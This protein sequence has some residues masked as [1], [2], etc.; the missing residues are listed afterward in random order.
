MR[1]MVDSAVS[2]FF[3]AKPRLK[4]HPQSKNVRYGKM[5]LRVECV[6]ESQRA[7]IAMKGKVMREV[8]QP[9]KTANN[10]V[11]A[12][13]FPPLSLICTVVFL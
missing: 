13:F 9:R 7:V 12:A 6:S 10:L 4:K 11:T 2:T 1:K 8:E 5:K 3:V